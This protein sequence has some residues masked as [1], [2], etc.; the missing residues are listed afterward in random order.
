DMIKRGIPLKK[1]SEKF[2]AFTYLPNDL[3]ETVETDIR[4]EGYIKKEIEQIEKAEKLRT[5]S[6]P[7]DV[8]Y[9]QIEGLRVE[10]REKLNE[11]KP[12]NLD[13]AGRISGVN[14]ADIAVL[15]VWLKGRND[16]R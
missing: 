10:A 5:K 12:L 8:D 4:Y 16:K 2:N 9:M 11:V 7:T 3:M 15:M 1:I 6:L 13:Q 14:P